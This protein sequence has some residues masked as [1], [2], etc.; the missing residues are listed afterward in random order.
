V[1]EQSFCPL[2]VPHDAAGVEDIWVDE[3]L[4]LDLGG[5]VELDFGGT[6]VYG[7]IDTPGFPGLQSKS[8]R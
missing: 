5:W 3:A 6:G 4:E 1:L 7:G 2:P 8:M